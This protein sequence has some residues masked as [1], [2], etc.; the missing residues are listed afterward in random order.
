MSSEILLEV[1]NLSVSYT[2][3]GKIAKAVDCVSF[4]L[5]RGEVLCIV[6]ESGCGKS[7]VAMA[8]PRLLPEPPAMVKATSI[9]IDG[10]EL[11]GVSRERLQPL[12]GSKIGVIFQDPMTALSPLHRIGDQLAESFLLHRREGGK[13]RLRPRILD[14]LDRVGIADPSRTINA[15]PHELS[16]GMQQRVM[17]AMALVHEPDLVIA[18]EPTTA[19]DVTTQAQVLELVK[20]L[21]REKEGKKSGL[22]L[23]THDM[24]VVRSIATHVAVMYAGQI[25]ETAP[26]A[27]LF[28]D[29]S[30]PYTQALLASMPGLATRGRRLPVIE[31]FVPSPA[32][33][34]SLPAC[35]FHPRCAW[36]SGC[37]GILPCP[38]GARQRASI[39]ASI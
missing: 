27:T 23:I 8:I 11:A 31:G 20:K 24:G 34:D 14:W 16:G 37:A 29:P 17:I 36:R 4:T 33:Y 32:E 39:R 15:Y 21:L 30:H 18:D 19:L 13:K 25:V 28:S 12:R 22:L 5:N 2:T 1:Q 10:I 6:G 38:R 26:C 3:D 7:T 9:K 35:R